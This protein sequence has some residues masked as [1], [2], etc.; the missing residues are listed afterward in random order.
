V[1]VQAHWDA[2][3]GYFARYHFNRMLRTLSE[4]DLVA[5]GINVVIFDN[6]VPIPGNGPRGWPAGRAGTEHLRR[7][8]GVVGHYRE[9]LGV[10]VWVMGHS[11]GGISV[12]ELL[13]HLQGSASSAMIAGLVYSAGRDGASFDGDT[14]L[15]VLLLH[16]EMDACP[17]TTPQHTLRTFN[18]LRERGNK[19]AEFVSIK[20]GEAEPKDPC[21]SGFHMYFGSGDEVPKAIDRY[22]AKHTAPR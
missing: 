16:H 1:G 10:P 13:K 18:K 15:P 9:K 2:S 8:E 7:I 3:H 5:G 14:T 12:T 6:P 20:G 4:P 22:V 17:N 21:V 19:V 11:N